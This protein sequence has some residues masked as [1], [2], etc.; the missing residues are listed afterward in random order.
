LQA[1]MLP[2]CALL[3][4]RK[5]ASNGGMLSDNTRPMISSLVKCALKRMIPLPE[6]SAFAR[7][8]PSNRR[9]SRR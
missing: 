7:T 8:P 4:R 5:R 1:L 3:V 2:S 6:S 9:P